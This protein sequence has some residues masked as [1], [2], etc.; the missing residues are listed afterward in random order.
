M[1]KSSRVT[2]GVAFCSTYSLR[3]IILLYKKI[4]PKPINYFGNFKSVG[5]ISYCMR[6]V[7]SVFV[8]RGIVLVTWPSYHAF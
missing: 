7:G 5:Y 4:R 1:N 6:S 8:D 3:S 2:V